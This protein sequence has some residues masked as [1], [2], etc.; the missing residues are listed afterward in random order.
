MVPLGSWHLRIL[1]A[2]SQ[3]AVG[4]AGERGPGQGLSPATATWP[5]SS[6]LLGSRLLQALLSTPWLL[7]SS[8][9]LTHHQNIT[10]AS[11]WSP[12]SSPL[13]TA[14]VLL[15]ISCFCLKAF[16]RSCH[17]RMETHPHLASQAPVTAPLARPQSSL[18]PP[19]GQTWPTPL[20]PQLHS[21][22]QSAPSLQVPRWE[23]PQYH[24]AAQTPGT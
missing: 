17:L 4:G 7:P 8:G 5:L 13:H 22:T 10:P 12:A 6:R 2:V 20:L 15:V 11:A 3:P 19:R 21:Y 16:S 1:T 9:H 24:P 18:W 14:I 23:V